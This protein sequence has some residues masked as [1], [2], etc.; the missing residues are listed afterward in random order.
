[1]T[2]V[3][4]YLLT[5]TFVVLL[6]CILFY[7]YVLNHVWVRV[8]VF[9]VYSFLFMLSLYVLNLFVLMF[10]GNLQF[11]FI[12]F[13]VVYFYEAFHVR[14]YLN[15]DT[16]VLFIFFIVCWTRGALVWACRKTYLHMCRVWCC[17]PQGHSIAPT[18]LENMKCS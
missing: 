17:D 13:L 18:W 1:M 12:Q 7:V 16:F 14:P 5:L 9:S 10:V 2:F 3:Y 4:V 11:Y 6:C 8:S 15:H